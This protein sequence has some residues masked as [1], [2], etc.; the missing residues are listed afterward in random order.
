[1]LILNFTTPPK[2]IK[3][4]EKLKTI[5]NNNFKTRTI[6]QNTASFFVIAM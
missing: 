1:M 3:A 2:D 4:D 5:S 6:M